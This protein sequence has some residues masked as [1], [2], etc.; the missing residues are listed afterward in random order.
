MGLAGAAESVEVS[1]FRWKRLARLVTAAARPPS[2]TRTS[3]KFS[4]SFFRP[5][6]SQFVLLTCSPLLLALINQTTVLDTFL[7]INTTLLLCLAVSLPPSPVRVARINWQ[8]AWFCYNLLGPSS[9]S[10][11]SLFICPCCLSISFPSCSSVGGLY[12][13]HFDY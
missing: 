5:S 4:S 7:C 13:G 12:S 10:L 1:G 3:R 2:R 11:Y 6:S 9:Y 8:L